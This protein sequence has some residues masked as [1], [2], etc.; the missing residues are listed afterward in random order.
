MSIVI[1][2]FGYAAACL[3]GNYELRH[4]FGELTSR[5]IIFVLTFAL[6]SWLCV[7]A[8]GISMGMRKWED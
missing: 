1:Y 3:I 6:G 4:E 5:D 8:L 7:I 2:L